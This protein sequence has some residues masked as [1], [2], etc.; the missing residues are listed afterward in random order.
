MTE[1]ISTPFSSFVFT[2]ITQSS[3]TASAVTS[4]TAAETTESTTA[5]SKSTNEILNELRQ[6][7]MSSTM[8]AQDIAD[9]YG[10]SLSKAQQILSELKGEQDGTFALDNPIPE[11]STVS[12]HV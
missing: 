2:S 6:D 8:S 12:Y 3:T 4:T 10:V 11:D 5:S 7:G 1:G 9:E